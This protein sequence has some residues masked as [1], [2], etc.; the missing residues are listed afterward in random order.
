MSP[1]PGTASNVGLNGGAPVPGPVVVAPGAVEVG[2]P[3]SG[4]VTDT[5]PCTGVPPPPAGTDAPPAP[6]LPTTPSRPG[7]VV[8]ADVATP[9]APDP[10]D[11][12][13]FDPLAPA[14]PPAAP[15]PSPPDKTSSATVSGVVG[16]KENAPVLAA[17]ETTPLR[18]TTTMAEASVARCRLVSTFSSSA[19]PAARRPCP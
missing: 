8:T 2:V 18:R 12:L 9:A 6:P 16:V 15:V 13:D 3:G 7:P 11:P 19:V 14:V 5:E 4:A 1:R 17:A 10:P